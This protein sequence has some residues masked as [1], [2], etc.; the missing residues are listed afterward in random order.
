MFTNFQAV[1]CAGVLGS[2]TLKAV[3]M[4]TV[5]F[6]RLNGINYRTLSI[7]NTPDQI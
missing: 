2:K 7:E 5:A 6:D 4:E 3:E 1:N